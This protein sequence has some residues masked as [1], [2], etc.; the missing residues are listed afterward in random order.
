MA[1]GVL[2]EMALIAVLHIALTSGEDATEAL[3]CPDQQEAFDSNCYE[4]VAQKRTFQGAQRW[5]ERGGGHLAFILNDETQQFLQRHLQPQ[6]DWWI[7]LAP[8]SV[9]LTLDSA[10]AEGS[11]TV[12]CMCVCV[13]LIWPVVLVLLSIY[14]FDI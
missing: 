9:N 8:A 6:Q 7:G 1:K 14:V 13:C 3:F 4:F 11:T 12:V 2:A 5:C 10:A